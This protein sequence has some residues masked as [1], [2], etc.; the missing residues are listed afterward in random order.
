MRPCLTLKP[1]DLLRGV[2]ELGHLDGLA[3]VFGAQDHTLGDVAGQV[4]VLAQLA[5]DDL[6]RN[7][8]E[9]LPGVGLEVAS[10]EP[11]P[12]MPVSSKATLKLKSTERISGIR[13]ALPGSKRVSQ[14]CSGTIP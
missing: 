6:L 11:G 10:H 14:A 8:L 7:F 4:R 5:G 12:T 3:D 13:G 2:A 9:L 1:V